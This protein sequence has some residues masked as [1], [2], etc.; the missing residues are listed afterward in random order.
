[1][2]GTATKM[3]ETAKVCGVQQQR[4]FSASPSLLD[5]LLR[6]QQKPAPTAIHNRPFNV[7]EL[8]S[9]P[10]WSLQKLL[11]FEPSVL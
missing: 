5:I 8:L 9:I 6:T 2:C 1:M 10:S 3:N 4:S 7:A 11:D